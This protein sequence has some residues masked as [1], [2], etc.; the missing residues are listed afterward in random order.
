VLIHPDELAWFIERHD[1]REWV[2]QNCAFAYSVVLQYLTDR[3]ETT[4]LDAWRRNLEDRRVHDTMLIDML[5]QLAGHRD[6]ARGGDKKE[7]IPRDLEELARIHLGLEI[8]KSNPFRRRFAEIIGKGWDEVDPEFFRYA[9]GVVIVTYL[10]HR[11]L[12]HHARRIMDDN[13]Y[14]PALKERFTIA[15]DAIERFGLL[16]EAVQVEGSI[17]LDQIART[18]MQIDVAR[19]EATGAEYRRRLDEM[20]AIFRRDYPGYFKTDGRGELKRTRGGAWQRSDKVLDEYLL[21]AAGEIAASGTAIE[22]PRTAKGLISH[23]SKKWAA[24]AGS[25]PFIELWCGYEAKTKLAQFFGSLKQPV[26]H[27]RYAVLKRTG[28]TGCSKP[29]VQQI[30]RRDE[31]RELFIASPGHLVLIIDYMRSDSTSLTPEGLS[32]A[33]TSLH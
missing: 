32:P 22:I 15:P 3:Q 7:L 8:D 23:S 26:I 14:D 12:T 24:H 30:P 31:F 4:A 1:D 9:I 16:S 10:L 25:H 28:R 2:F 6:V 27:P 11:E 29:N 20:V 17:A 18:G 13:G 21:R 19:V 5:L 33:T